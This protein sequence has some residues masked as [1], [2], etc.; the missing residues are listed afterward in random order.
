VIR[1]SGDRRN[2]VDDWP[3][4]A[5]RVNRPDSDAGGYLVNSP[6]LRMLKALRNE[7]DSFVLD[8]WGAQEAKINSAIKAGRYNV[9]DK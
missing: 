6:L 4:S 8:G 9:K 3:E 2:P 1:D 5:T 7:C